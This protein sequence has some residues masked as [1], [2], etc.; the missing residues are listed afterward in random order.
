MPQVDNVN[1]YF[2]PMLLG[3]RPSKYPLHLMRP[4]QF[5]EGTEYLVA[6]TFAMSAG[7]FKIMYSLNEHRLELSANVTLGTPTISFTKVGVNTQSISWINRVQDNQVSFIL[8]IGEGIVRAYSYGDIV[9]QEDMVLDQAYDMT[10]FN[11]TENNCMSILKMFRIIEGTYTDE[12]VQWLIDQGLLNE[13]YSSREIRKVCAYDFNLSTISLNRWYSTSRQNYLYSDVAINIA[14]GFAGS[15]EHKPLPGF[16]P[17]VSVHKPQIS[18]TITYSNK[19]TGELVIKPKSAD[20]T[21][22][23]HKYLYNH[24]SEYSMSSINELNYQNPYTVVAYCY[25]LTSNPLFAIGD[26]IYRAQPSD[27]KWRLIAVK[28]D[29]NTVEE[30]VNYVSR[31]QRNLQFPQGILRLNRGAGSLAFFKIYEGLLTDIQM[32]SYSEDV[33]HYEPSNRLLYDLSDYNLTSLSWMDSVS[34]LGVYSSTPVEIY[35]APQVYG[36]GKVAH[37]SPI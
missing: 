27:L 10:L 33:Y 1:E 8:Q 13:R 16:N 36:V 14:R 15:V 29:G 9:A 5:N 2:T 17:Y 11:S 6:C 7:S 34:G 4:L 24:G 3:V 31:S 30:V 37:V 35:T 21:M 28:F 19:K 26:Y 32:Q 20:N 12:Q 23:V 25:P 22:R 18:N